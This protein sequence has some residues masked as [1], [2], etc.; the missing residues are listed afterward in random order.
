MEETNEQPKVIAGGKLGTLTLGWGIILAAVVIVFSLIIFLLDVDRQS[1]INYFSYVIIIAGII[2]AQT[3]YKNKHLGGFISYGKAFTVGFVMM[4]YAG[5]IIAIWTFIFVKFI[6]PGSL[7][8]AMR[9]SEER[10]I[11]RG[12]SDLEIEQSWPMVKALNSPTAW[13]LF[14]FLGNILTGVVVSLITAIF[15]KNEDP[16]AMPVA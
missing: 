15:V 2:I 12:M 14:A 8:E 16:N 3:T 7:E 10:M 6:D 13:T 11:E 9:I 1:W 5:I 4:I